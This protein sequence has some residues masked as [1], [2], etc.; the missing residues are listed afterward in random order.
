M[1]NIK[2]G[3]RRCILCVLTVFIVGNYPLPALAATDA[4]PPAQ[5][6]PVASD[7][8]KPSPSLTYT[9]NQATGRW[10]SNKWVYDAAS[11]TYVPAPQAPVAT[12][13]PQPG[14]DDSSAAPANTPTQTNEPTVTSTANTKAS[15]SNI[16]D[17][18]A[19]SGSATVTNN[20][21]AGSATSGSAS[22][23]ATVING[24]ASSFSASGNSPATFVSDIV[25]NVYGDI[26]LYPTIIKNIL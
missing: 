20:T 3:I 10:D 18:N 17:S 22:A 9:Y 14:S 6:T 24:I 12:Q 21:T 26:M 11:G 1:R 13:S 25:G 15:I 4:T 16:L 2:D 8:A 19:S 23:S 5:S 7:S